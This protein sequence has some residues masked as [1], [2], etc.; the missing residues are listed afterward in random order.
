MSILVVHGERSRKAD[1]GGC[2]ILSFCLSFF[3]FFFIYVNE[4]EEEEELTSSSSSRR[5][6][7]CIYGGS[8][9]F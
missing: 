6:L 2:G 4:W 3:F 1:F 8:Q 7:T 9:G 5:L